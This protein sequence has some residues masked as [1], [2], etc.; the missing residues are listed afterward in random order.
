M[1]ADL[2]SLTDVAGI[3]VGHYDRSNRNWR[4][5]TTVVLAEHPVTAGVDVRGGGPGTRETDALSPMNLVDKVDAIC[6][7]GGSAYGLRAADGVVDELADRERGFRVGP[8]AHQV[9]PVIPSAVIF[10]LGRGGHFRHHPDAEF[11]RRA[12]RS[13]SARERRRGSIGAGTGAVAG[14][15]RGG[16]GMASATIDIPIGD[17][18]V[19]NVTIAAL[20]VVNARGSLIDPSSGRAWE[21]H[22]RLKSPSSADRQRYAEHVD[23]V[24]TAS[25]NTTI[26]VVATDAQIDRSEA[27]RLAMSSHDGLARSI[28][29][30]HT[31]A[32]GDTMFAMATGSVDIDSLERT[33]ALSR[34]SEVAAD[35]TAL[36]CI[37]AIVHAEPMADM[38]SYTSLCPSAL[39]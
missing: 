29:P 4:T 3:R 31:L 6:L 5:G 10:D 24:K 20:C 33:L 26:G 27:T 34:L 23:S 7:S 13:A 18:K 28:R 15:L 8:E 38:P 9:V 22:P 32:D 12:T 14:G 16:I 11:G 21:P 2:G 37:D 1:P 19:S 25:F 17:E 39:R 35:V 30:V 36:A